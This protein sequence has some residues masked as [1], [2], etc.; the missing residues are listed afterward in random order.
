MEYNVRYRCKLGEYETEIEM[1]L[2]PD[3]WEQMGQLLIATMKKDLEVEKHRETGKDLLIKVIYRVE[4]DQWVIDKGSY[5]V[6]EDEGGNY[7]V[8]EL[9]ISKIRALSPK[10]KS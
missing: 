3:G 2:E 5:H 6:L 8:Q 9:I 7:P 4:T 1:S 10:G